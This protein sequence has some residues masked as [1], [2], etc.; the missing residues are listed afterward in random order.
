MSDSNDYPEFLKAFFSPQNLE[1]VRRMQEAAGRY[2]E[3]F[4]TPQ[5]RELTSQLERF[6][7]TTMM[8][9]P[10][11]RAFVDYFQHLQENPISK[12]MSTDDM[13]KISELF[14]KYTPDQLFL[15]WMNE[16]AKPYLDQIQKLLAAYKMRGS[17]E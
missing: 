2:Q 5:M 8:D 17:E 10:H 7:K 16:T 9:S 6:Q 4:N 11:M 1:T 12:V 3:A 15:A 13:A 14:K